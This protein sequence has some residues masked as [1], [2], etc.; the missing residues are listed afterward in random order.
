MKRRIFILS[1]FA[2]GIG[3]VL[4][5]GSFLA[6]MGCFFS[7][8]FVIP[9]GDSLIAEKSEEVISQ[10]KSNRII[11]TNSSNSRITFNRVG[12]MIWDLIDGRKSC[13]QISDHLVREF[14]IDKKV[15]LHDVNL[16]VANLEKE[17]YLKATKIARNYAIKKMAYKKSFSLWG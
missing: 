15:A 3:S 16:F 8:K 10:I 6:W 7:R 14:G 13:D 9:A 11:A 4:G 1:C 17:G 5:K 2:V 12:A